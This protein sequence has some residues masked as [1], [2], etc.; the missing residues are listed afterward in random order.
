[1]KVKCSI[2]VPVYNT[3]E[4]LEICLES[5]RMQ[6][7]TDF[8]VIMINDG[9]TD[10]SKDICTEYENKD[11]R[12]HL[13]NKENGGVGSARNYAMPYIHGEYTIF[14][15]SDDVLCS[16][17]LEYLINVQEISK[18]RVV[19]CGYI[20]TKDVEIYC[21]E[22][23]QK[24]YIDSNFCVSMLNDRCIGT[25]PWNKMIKTSLFYS[26]NNVEKFPEHLRVGEDEVWLV[27]TLDKES[28]VAIIDLPLY[29]YRIRENSATNS[30]KNGISDKDGDDLLAQIELFDYF[31]DTGDLKKAIKARLTKKVLNMKII[32]YA[33]SQ[34]NYQKM[35]DFYI[36]KYKCGI[37]DFMC[38]GYRIRLKAILKYT[39]VLVLIN[40]KINP[41]IIKFLYEK[42]V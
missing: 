35:S 37:K 22:K 13:I 4:Y 15:D 24:F 10:C 40:F 3:Q 31:D 1:M 32:S 21:C 8:E 9:S 2:V 20:E 36:K 11:S 25:A 23:K 16:N 28:M 26:K 19:C 6:T 17:M 18:S 29:I 27:K 39:A 12:F 14:I 33:Y 41:R 30:E 42:L 7:Y 34:K 38:W 5:I